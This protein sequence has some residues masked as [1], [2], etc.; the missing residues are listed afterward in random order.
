MNANT[1]PTP[2]TQLDPYE[3]AFLTGGPAR[4]ADVA[5]LVLNSSGAL[6]ISRDGTVTATGHAPT[7][8]VTAGVLRGVQVAGGTA[9]LSVVRHEGARCPEIQAVGD[10][11][12]A[13]GLLR[14]PG[15]DPQRPP[16]F[17][18]LLLGG[19]AVAVALSLVA[20]AANS[21]AMALVLLVLFSAFVLVLS[22]SAHLLVRQAQHTHLGTRTVA[23]LRG[24]LVR[25]RRDGRLVGGTDLAEIAIFG[26][27]CMRDYDL[28]D[29][30]RRQRIPQGGFGT[31][32]ARAEVA[33][34]AGHLAAAAAESAATWCG[35]A[36]CADSSFRGSACSSSDPGGGWSCGGGGGSSCGGGGGGSSCGGGGGGGGCG[37]GGGGSS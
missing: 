15:S 22:L 35:N 6:H 14:P 17:V 31:T 3:T 10:R 27:H 36:S 32:E 24:D 5:V 9:P 13:G 34:Q 29:V 2:I 7:D 19:T 1:A 28:L 11:L 4:A 23:Q 25:G 16:S 26:V 8:P 12:L 33:A 21:L 30:F 20:V 37:G 18:A